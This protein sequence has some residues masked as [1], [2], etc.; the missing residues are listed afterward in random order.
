MVRLKQPCASSLLVPLNGMDLVVV[1]LNQFNVAG[2]LN[3]LRCVEPLFKFI[4]QFR[5]VSFRDRLISDDLRNLFFI[6]VCGSV[7]CLLCG[8]IPANTIKMLATTSSYRCGVSAL[9]PLR[10]QLAK[11]SRR[12]HVSG[13]P[14]TSDIR[15]RG[16]HDRFVP[17]PAVSRCSIRAKHTY[18][19][20]G[21][22]EEGFRGHRFHCFDVPGTLSKIRSGAPSFS[23][24][25][26]L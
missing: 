16:W 10:P 20:V 17:E 14:P 1:F 13:L 4:Q 3:G 21:A 7:Y 8:S 15:R 6:A 19:L 2:I 5:L 26:C 23:V 9:S 25:S 12:A 18:H 24:T 22:G 11:C